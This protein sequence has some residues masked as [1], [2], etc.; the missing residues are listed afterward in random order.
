MSRRLIYIVSAKN[1]LDVGSWGSL[2]WPCYDVLLLPKY[3]VKHCREKLADLCGF[4]QNSGCNSISFTFPGWKSCRRSWERLVPF[5]PL[6]S[7]TRKLCVW[8]YL[9]DRCSTHSLKREF[10]STRVGTYRIRHLCPDNAWDRWNDTFDIKRRVQH[11][12]SDPS[13][14]HSV[15]MPW[16]RSFRKVSTAFLRRALNGTRHRLSEK[17]NTRSYLLIHNMR[18]YNS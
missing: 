1:G 12:F 7:A 3:R 16:R 11:A 10:S 9:G 17:R 15:L 14:V 6:I 4:K 18:F 8:P 5:R 13:H 2:F